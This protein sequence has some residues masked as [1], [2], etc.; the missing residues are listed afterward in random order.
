MV[1]KLFEV[2]VV[3]NN[4]DGGLSR[5]IDSGIIIIAND[6]KQAKGMAR[7]LNYRH[8][9]EKLEFIIK[10]KYPQEKDNATKEKE[11]VYIP[12]P[13]Y[14][15]PRDPYYPSPIICSSNTNEQK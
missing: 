7:L 5:I 6:I 1:G 11:I 9:N 8:N 15:Y 2:T 13:V 10:E 3:L 14:V 4:D 12:Y